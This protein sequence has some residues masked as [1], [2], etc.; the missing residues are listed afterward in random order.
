MDDLLGEIHAVST[1]FRME[2]LHNSTHLLDTLVYL[3][4]SRA[5]CVSGYVTGENEAVDSLDIDRTVDDAGGGGYV[6]TNVNT[7]ITVDCTI[8]RNDLSMMNILFGTEGKLYTNNDDGECRY[9]SPED[10]KH[11]E[12]PLPGIEGE[13]TWED[14]YRAAFPAATEHIVELLE[15]GGENR[16]S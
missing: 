9:W 16:V 2:L 6:I 7:F 1:Q 8:P 5:A 14:D 3:L 12:Q 15:D 4:D 10:G 11:I 13:W